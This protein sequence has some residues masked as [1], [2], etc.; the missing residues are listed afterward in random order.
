MWTKWNIL[1]CFYVKCE[2]PAYDFINYKLSKFFSS[3]ILHVIDYDDFAD[4]P[5]S[6]ISNQ[7]SSPP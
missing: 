2:S 1:E 4:S 5:A 3:V 6:E 7:S